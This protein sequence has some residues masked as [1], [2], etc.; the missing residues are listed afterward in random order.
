MVQGLGAELAQGRIESNRNLQPVCEISSLAVR[1][2][3]ILRSISIPLAKAHGLTGSQKPSADEQAI[4][5]WMTSC[6]A[7]AATSGCTYV[8]S[9][10]ASGSTARSFVFRAVAEHVCVRAGLVLRERCVI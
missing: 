8:V 4:A 10:S 2:R 9:S 7:H 1:V 5:S 3:S 6:S